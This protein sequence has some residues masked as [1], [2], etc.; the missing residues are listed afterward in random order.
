MSMPQTASTTALRIEESP[1]VSMITEMIG[2]A[3]GLGYAV[4]YAFA[5]FQTA[6]VLADATAVALLGLALD[7]LLVAVRDRLIFWEKLEAYYA[8]S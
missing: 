7:G 6:R 1:R 5:S 2:S 4:I 8:R 3:D